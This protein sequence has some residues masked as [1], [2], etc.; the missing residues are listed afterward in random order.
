MQTAVPASTKKAGSFALPIVFVLWLSLACTGMTALWLYSAAPGRDTRP[1]GQWPGSSTLQRSSG[2][3]T[4]VMFVHPKCPCS[5]ASIS[6]LAVLLAHSGGHLH[7]QIV[8]LKPLGEE[9]SWTHTDLSRAASELPGTSV[10][11]DLEGREAKLFHAAVSGET[12]VYDTLGILRF[13]GGITGAR[14]HVGDN[15]GCSSVEAYA[16]TG[17]VPLSKTP[18]FGCPLFN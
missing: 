9:D 6:E 4:L 12:L 15:A 18:V 3:S 1:P 10:L 5:R 14:G 8:F 7:A 2:A 13:H 16:N 11:N 17:A